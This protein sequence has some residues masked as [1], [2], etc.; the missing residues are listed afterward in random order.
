VLA[1]ESRLHCQNDAESRWGIPL[2]RIVYEIFLND[3]SELLA[4]D[5]FKIADIAQSQHHID[6][7]LI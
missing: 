1:T 4:S 7:R 6:G 2:F 5:T 3:I